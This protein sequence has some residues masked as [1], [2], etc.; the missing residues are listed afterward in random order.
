MSLL[1]VELLEIL[2][3]N[4]L[5]LLTETWSC[6]LLHVTV[7]GFH[8]VRLDRLLKNK[9]AKRDSVELLF[10]LKIGYSNIQRL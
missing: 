1:S 3:K 9:S 10:I 6:P 4:D 5:I 2:C 8:E 7:N